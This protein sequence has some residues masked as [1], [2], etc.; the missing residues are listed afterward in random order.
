MLYGLRETTKEIQ[1][2]G[3]RKEDKR[4]ETGQD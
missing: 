2:Y 3:G 4:V 1:S